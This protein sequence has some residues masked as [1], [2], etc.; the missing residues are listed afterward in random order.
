MRFTPVLVLSI[1]L[2]GCGGR[3][4]INEGCRW[5]HDAAFPL[6]LT[7]G[8]HQQHLRADADLAEDLAIRFADAHRG[9]VAGARATGQTW[10]EGRDSCMA[11]LFTEIEK[12]HGVPAAEIRRWMGLRDLS[13]DLPVFVTFLTWLALLARRLSRRLLNGW[14]FRG[15]L[16]VFAVAVTSVA[17][18]AAGGALGA[19]WFGLFEMIRL[20]SEHV[21]G[22]G[23]RP[24][25]PYYLA[26]VFAAAFLIVGATMWRQHLAGAGR[27]EDPMGESRILFR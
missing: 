11:E 7:A 9:R 5:T 10:A 17:A 24:P 16:E 27:S 14:S 1:C 23:F 13:Y 8:G 20:G 18:G 4:R 6:D 3:D 2:A 26:T 19:L 12:R 15:R 22:R 21:S 25:W